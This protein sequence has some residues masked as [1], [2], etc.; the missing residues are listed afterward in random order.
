[1]KVGKVSVEVELATEDAELNCEQFT[2]RAAAYL[3]CVERRG[4]LPA[5]LRPVKQHLSVCRECAELFQTLW[6]ATRAVRSPRLGG[7]A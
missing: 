5:G 3:E 6:D 1:M 7:P 4:A 2:D